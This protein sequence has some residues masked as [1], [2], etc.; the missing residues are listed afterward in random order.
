MKYISINTVQQNNKKNVD[1][2]C[3]IRLTPE[4]E[5]NIL[6]SCP[7]ADEK[8]SFRDPGPTST[9][10]FLGETM[11]ATYLMLLDPK[12]TVGKLSS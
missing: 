1:Q 3:H 11:V 4:T 9:V 2:I 10:S 8:E 7:D 12:Q 6:S 5:L